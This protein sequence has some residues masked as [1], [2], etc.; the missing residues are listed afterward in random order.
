MRWYKKLYV[1][2][3]L[4]NKT[5][6][7]KYIIKYT[8]KV[9]GTYCI[10]PASGKKDLLDIC[11]SELLRVNTFYADDHIVVGI[12]GSRRGAYDV[13]ASIVSDSIKHTG[14]TDVKGFLGV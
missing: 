6:Y 4:K 11:H 10:L 5:L 7:Y 13:A 14:N 8:K 1:G 9:T 2:E 3:S 12:A